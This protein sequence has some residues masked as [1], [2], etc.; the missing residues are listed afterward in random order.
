MAGALFGYCGRRGAPT[1]NF[2]IVRIRILSHNGELNRLIT[3]ALI[4]QPF[5]NLLL[6]NP[7]TAV[8]EGYNGEIFRFTPEERELVVSIRATSLV[9]YARQ[10]VKRSNGNGYKNKSIQ[11]DR[12]VDRPTIFLRAW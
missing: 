1:V 6:T 12:V 11:V 10:L 3:A 4:S 8:D 2:N 5:R 7:D 9:D